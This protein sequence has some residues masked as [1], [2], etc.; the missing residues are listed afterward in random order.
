MPPPHPST[1]V[2]L[3]LLEQLRDEIGGRVT[4]FSAQDTLLA[5][6]AGTHRVGVLLSGSALDVRVRADGSRALIDLIEPGDLLGENWRSPHGLQPEEH[7]E[8]LAIGARAGRIL[9]FDLARVLADEG[10]SPELRRLHANLLQH[11]LVKQER[12]RAKIEILSL[13]SLRDRLLAYLRS[14]SHRAGSAEFSIPFS[15]A[16]L[17]EYLH[18]DRSALSRELSRLRDRGLLRF[19][20]SEFLLLQPE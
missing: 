10:E 18:A 1:A 5:C 9:V 13:P 2:D 19:H 17:A 16:E 12:L 20:K 4:A 15:R 6:A 7:R 3:R 8:R 14:A 11:T